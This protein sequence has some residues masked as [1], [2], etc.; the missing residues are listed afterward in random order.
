MRNFRLF[1]LLLLSFSF[2]ASNCTKEGPEGPVGASGPQ[3]PPGSNGTPGTPGPT[4]PSGPA[5]SANV[6]Y[7]AWYT[8]VTGDYTATGVAPY[9]AVFLF[10][11]AA[12]G[13]DPIDHR[14]WHRPLLYERLYH[15]CD[16]IRFARP[17]LSNCLTWPTLIQLTITIL[18]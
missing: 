6:T 12:A 1:S 15:C 10:D 8:T 11:K 17:M 5:G 13:S 7:S 16:S 3:G 2:I 9:T 14:Q 4:G 18:Y